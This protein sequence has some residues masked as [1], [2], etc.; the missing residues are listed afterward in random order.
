MT[1]YTVFVLTTP[2]AVHIAGTLSNVFVNSNLHRSFLEFLRSFYQHSYINRIQSAD[3]AT[4]GT[5]EIVLFVRSPPE[6]T[7]WAL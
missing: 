4:L 5:L 7:W 1:D 3:C 6:D 2:V